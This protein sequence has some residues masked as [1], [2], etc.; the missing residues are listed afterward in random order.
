VTIALS[1]TIRPQF[2]LNVC[3]AEINRG[4]VILVK[5]LECSPW[6]RSMMSGSADSEH[7]KL[8]NREIIFEEFQPM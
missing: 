4:W 1:L 6:S 5:F 3:D 7:P 8:R 2:V